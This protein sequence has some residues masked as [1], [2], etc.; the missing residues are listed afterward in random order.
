[1]LRYVIRMEPIGSMPIPQVARLV[2]PTIDR[3]LTEPLSAS[4]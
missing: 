4:S 3:Y 1:M 2:G